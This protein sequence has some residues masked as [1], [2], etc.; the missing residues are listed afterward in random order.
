MDAYTAFLWVNICVLNSADTW[1][2]GKAL[3]QSAWRHHGKHGR[4][5]G[6]DVLKNGCFI[7]ESVAARAAMMED[8][9]WVI[10][11]AAVAAFAQSVTVGRRC[12]VL[13]VLT[14]RVVRSSP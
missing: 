11:I 4:E 12:F 9:F 13:T 7:E 5:R 1:E 6:C 10:V 8:S 14:Y 3:R 2:K